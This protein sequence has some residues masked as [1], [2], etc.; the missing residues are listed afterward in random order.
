MSESDNLELALD[1]IVETLDMELV[2]ALETEKPSVLTCDCG[3]NV[4]HFAVLSNSFELVHNITDKFLLETRTDNGYTP[5]YMAVKHNNILLAEYFLDLG[6][7]PDAL[8]DDELTPLLLAIENGYTD[9]A[10]LLLKHCAIED[11]YTDVI[12]LYHAI[13]HNQF[14]LVKLLLDNS[15]D[16]N[17]KLDKTGKTVLHYAVEKNLLEFVKLLFSYESL[18]SVCVDNDG[19]APIHVAVS[20]KLHDMVDL[21]LEYSPVNINTVNGIGWSVLH[22]AVDADDKEMVVYLI[23]K[24]ASTTVTNNDGQTPIDFATDDHN[25]DMVTLLTYCPSAKRRRLS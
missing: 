5:L 21:L 18:D 2:E 12:P 7:D 11:G 4:L 3:Y 9:M 10:Q 22:A 13:K 19:V 17:I 15:A 24:G 1:M 8:D 16:I 14:D 6:A 25:N 20:D 23:D